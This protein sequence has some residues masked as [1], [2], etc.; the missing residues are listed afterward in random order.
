MGTNT[1]LDIVGAIMI[2]GL[3]MLNMTRL[4]TSSSMHSGQYAMEA[5]VEQNLVDVF[6]LMEGDLLKIGYMRGQEN[7]SYS[8]QVITT[9]DTN[10]VVF[11]ADVDDD[12]SFETVEYSV[13]RRDS[14]T[15]TNNPFDRPFYRKVDGAGPMIGSYGITQFF[16]EY[17]DHTGVKLATPVANKGQISTIS[18]TVAV[19]SPYLSDTNFP[20][21]NAKAYWKQVRLAIPNLRY[22]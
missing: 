18:I 3:L 13:G 19:E 8:G 7:L 16:L 11:L 4:Y 22:K 6:T 12:G 9:A 20:D 17:F 14:L 21:Y 2:G 15:I 5:I 10:K 1:L